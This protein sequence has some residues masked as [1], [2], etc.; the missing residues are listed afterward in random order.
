MSA[1][2]FNVEAFRADFPALAQTS[3]DGAPLLFADNAST[4]LKP[5]AVIDA[6]LGYYTGPCA[7]VHR[8]VH[9][10]AEEAGRRYEGARESVAELIGAR[11]QEVIFVRNTTEAIHLAAH[12][13]GV[14][15]GDEVVAALSD[16][17]SNLLPWRRG[18]LTLVPPGPAGELRAEDFRAAIG[19]KTRLVAV[20][21]A[22]NVTG[23]VA[24]VRE[25]ARAARER[26]AAVLID[27]A[28][29]AAHLPLDV[30]EIGCDFLAFSGHKTLGPSGIGALFA[31]AERT[32]GAPPLITGGGMVDS[33]GAEAREITPAPVP[34]RFEAGT[35]NIEGA[36][37]LGAAAELLLD[38]EMEAV[39][40]HG[41]ALSRALDRE[42]LS[43][44]G[45]TMYPPARPE[46]LERRLPTRAFT[47]GDLPTDQ[48]AEILSQRH[49]ILLASGVHCAEPLARHWGVRSL[50]RVSLHPYNTEAEVR[51][52]G[53]ALRSLAAV[54]RSSR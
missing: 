9:R 28:Q 14:G 40:E 44:E 35:P 49:G 17:H 53:E 16:H 36:L 8:G 23:L 7:N 31:R 24:P 29:T 26:G 1:A 39:E 34:H 6:V 20:A 47:L 4:S 51:R 3:P 45:L 11:R 52:L 2:A 15:E 27:A 10:L 38:L 54:F 22:S 41:R 30:G 21:H 43:V 12:L 32:E 18:R 42:L 13:L 33:V 50:L 5:Q 19:P 48:V 37:G 25:I 46:S